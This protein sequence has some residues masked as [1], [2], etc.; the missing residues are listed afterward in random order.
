MSRVSA[1]ARAFEACI[2]R[3][4]V[5]LFPSDTVYGLACSPADADAIERLYALK[6]RRPEKASAVMFFSVPAALEA[7]PELG[8]RTRGALGRLLP[9]A[10]TVLLANP[11]A[12]FPLACPA[13]PSTLGV[14]VVAV[15]VLAGVSVPV[16]QSSAN[17]AGGAD[18]RRLEQV[19]ESIREGADLVLDGGELPGVASTVVDLREFE[20]AGLAA[21][22]VIRAGAVSEGAIAAALAGF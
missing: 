18:A 3:G 14:R 5:A 6:H 1:S 12:R 21:V 22:R 11:R 17:P 7:L 16:L 4:G 8:E 15:D 2:G 13:D 19:A 20:A 9:G 10:V